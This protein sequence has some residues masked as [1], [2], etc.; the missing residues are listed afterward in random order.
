MTFGQRVTIMRKQ[1][2]INQSELGTLIGTSG[3][4]VSKYE[5]DFITP[6]IDVAAKIA[7]ALNVSID[8]LVNGITTEKG[9]ITDEEANQLQHFDQLLPEDK[10]HVLAVVDAFLTKSKLQSLIG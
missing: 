8:Y 10:V 1:K 4:I 9:P 5:R 2:N 6:S 3:N 7:K